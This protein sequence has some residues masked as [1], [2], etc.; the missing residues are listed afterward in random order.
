MISGEGAPGFGDTRD[1]KSHSRWGEDQLFFSVGKHGQVFWRN[2]PAKWTGGDWS[3]PFALQVVTPLRVSSSAY[4][5]AKSPGMWG[6]AKV[7][8]GRKHMVM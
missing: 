6:F 1:M 5:F 4:G 7:P 3:C 2:S 8:S